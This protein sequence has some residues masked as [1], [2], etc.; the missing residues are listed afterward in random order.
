VNEIDGYL[1]SE[2]HPEIRAGEVYLC[3]ASLDDFQNSIGWK[4]KRLGKIAFDISGKIIPLINRLFPVFVLKK[5]L[6]KDEV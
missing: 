6:Q 4:S 1:T 3:N 5:E 2:N